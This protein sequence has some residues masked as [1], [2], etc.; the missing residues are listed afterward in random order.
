MRGRT[1]FTI[2]V[3][4]LLAIAAFTLSQCGVAQNLFGRWGASATPTPSQMAD[5][6]LDPKLSLDPVGGF[7]GTNVSVEGSGWKPGEMVV[8]KLQDA[9][10]R[11]S[12]LTAKL[13]DGDGNFSSSF[14]YPIG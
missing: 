12:V 7:T 2:V 6:A 10:G 5:A 3:I 13:A 9:D 4:A 11:S 1:F 8:L 14:S